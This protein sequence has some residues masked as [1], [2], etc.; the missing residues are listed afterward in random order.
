ME[1][2]WQFIR[3]CLVGGAGLIVN[4]AVTYCLVELAGWWYLAAFCVGTLT[5][6]STSFVLNALVTFPEHARGAYGK[7]YILYLGLYAAVF[8]INAAL[9]YTLTS[10]IGVYYLA[11]IVI[12]ALITTLITYQ[13][14]K[15]VIYA[16]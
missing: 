14:S 5:A 8:V 4:L 6:W 9:V 3:F 2:Y 16:P 11:S 1:R 10:L 15:H 7:K 13:T 12:S